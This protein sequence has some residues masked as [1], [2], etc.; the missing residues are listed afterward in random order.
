V[1]L[2][3]ISFAQTLA[4]MLE[5]AYIPWNQEEIKLWLDILKIRYFISTVAKETQRPKTK[6][7]RP[8][9]LEGTSKRIRALI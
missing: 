1:Y 9:T 2:M 5:G 3:I 4:I 8:K 6:D 7:Q